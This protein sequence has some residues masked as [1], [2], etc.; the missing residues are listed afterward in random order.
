MRAAITPPRATCSRA[1]SRRAPYYHEFH[2][3]LAR[4]Y[5]GL[6]DEAQVKKHLALAAENST[7]RKDHDLYQAKLDQIRSVQ[8]R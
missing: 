5:A 1:K 8:V 2:Y 4:A 3:W 6:G 7:T